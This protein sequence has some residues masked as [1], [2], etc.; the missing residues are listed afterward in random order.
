[1]KT[2]ELNED[3]VKAHDH[4]L[5]W[6]KSKKALLTLGGYA[7]TGKTTTISHTIQTLR[8]DTEKGKDLRIAFCG[9]TGKAA[10][11]LGAKLKAA[12]A[13]L[14]G[15]DYCG[16]IHSLIYRPFFNAKGQI[17]GF[18]L[19]SGT[20]GYDLIAV[21]E[22]SM[23]NEQIYQ[24][25]SSFGVPILAIGDHGQLPPVMGKFNLM[26]APEIRLEKIMRQAEDNPIIR[27]SMIAREEGEI[28]EG[29]YGPGVRK[30]CDKKK[31]REMSDFRG[32]NRIILCGRNK[33]RCYTNN[34]VRSRLGYISPDPS[35]GE[36][37]ICLRNNRKR[38]IYNG[39]IGII[40]KIR[41]SGE[42]WFWA[43]IQIDDLVFSG[44]IFRHQF[45]REKLITEWEDF[46]FEEIGNLFDFS[47]CLTVHKSQGSEFDDVIV[48]EE[49]MGMQTD[50]D[51]RRW[52]Y[53]A[54]TRSREK[55]LI[56]GDE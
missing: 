49:R 37:V 3:Q 9:F 31:I 10:S 22:A 13:F 20:L 6:I 17:A 56:L 43:D 2:I 1:M 54:C 41:K 51:W 28:P 11:V 19:L 5:E 52:L 55:L 44:T 36:P 8:E 33:T 16:T 32:N 25:L 21:D 15:H 48:I 38:G 30:I 24:D 53:T 18:E 45:G 23:L 50:E 40:Q 12:G 35:V 14:E 46:E 47:Y 42:H 4:I 27:V 26:E 7:G 34:F 29:E 39:N